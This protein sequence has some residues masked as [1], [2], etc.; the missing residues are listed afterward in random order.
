MGV[1]SQATAVLSVAALQ[2]NA[3]QMY[4]RAYISDGTYNGP[5]VAGKGIQSELDPANDWG[6]EARQWYGAQQG[7]VPIREEPPRTSSFVLAF[8]VS[9]IDK[10]YGQLGKQALGDKNKLAGD[11]VKIW[12]DKWK[13]AGW[14]EPEIV[15]WWKT[16]APPA[17]LG[18]EGSKAKGNRERKTAEDRTSRAEAR[19]ER[20]EQSVTAA[21][22]RRQ[23][24]TDQAA[25]LTAQYD[26]LAA[27]RQARTETTTT[28]LNQ[29]AQ[30]L[31]ARQGARR[32]TRQAVPTLAERRAAREAAQAA[33]SAR[34]GHGR[35]VPSYA[36][37]NASRRDEA[38]LSRDPDTSTGNV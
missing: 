17:R 26:A 12:E 11:Y 27:A 5:A 38:D 9:R 18:V 25:A 31:E 21:E 24:A 15:M 33:S 28:Q 30:D 3:V 13:K 35:Y 36:R 8:A 1:F 20:Q 6:L 2:V 29:V 14:S 10:I 23:A 37:R 4:V 19:V 32:A 34:P 22:Q 16:G 7:M